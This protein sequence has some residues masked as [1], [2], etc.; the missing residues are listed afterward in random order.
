MFEWNLITGWETADLEF[1]AYWRRFY[2]RVIVELNRSAWKIESLKNLPW[3]KSK[4]Q[5]DGSES[6]SSSK[7]LLFARVGL[8][9]DNFVLWR[10]ILKCLSHK[11]SYS[12]SGISS[13][14]SMIFICEK[15]S[16][17]FTSEYLQGIIVIIFFL[18]FFYYF[19]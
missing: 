15:L 17:S 11:I 6:R 7:F 9:V 16:R 18:I 4:S 1:F 19:V 8:N 2:V 13:C 3:I 12:L 5:S 10:R 14:W